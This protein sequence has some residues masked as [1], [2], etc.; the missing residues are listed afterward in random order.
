MRFAI[1]L[2]A[3]AAASP[4]A[5][6][7]PAVE[8]TTVVSLDAVIVSAERT[9]T[10][11][12]SSVSSVS[13]IDA[14]QL[15]QFPQATVADALQQV[16]GFALATFD[17]LGGD[18]Q[19]MVRGFYG[20]GEAEY[21]VVL[22]DGRPFN[23][24]QNGLIAWDAIPLS[25]IE[26]IEVVRGG[27]SA[28]YGDAAIGGV[29]NIITRDVS[30][31]MPAR[32][33]VS[34]G[35]HDTFSGDADVGV[36]LGG[37]GIG[38]SGAIDRTA[39]FRDHAERSSFR[40]GVRA[41]L[42]AG[43]TASL[44]LTAHT[45]ARDFQEA[46]AVLGST[47]DA[48]RA[49]SDPIFRFDETQ[50]R[51]HMLSLLGDAVF[52]ARTRLTGSITGEYR[53]LDAV[54]TLPLAPGYGD[55]KERDT[56]TTRGFATAQLEIDDTFLP[57]ADHL[58]FGADLTAGRF[59]SEYYVI[60]AGTSADYAAASGERG[61]LDASGTGSRAAAGAFAQY[62]VNL[63]RPLRLVL[64]AR[65][66]AVR[67][68]FDASAPSEDDGITASHDEFSPK[69][70]LNFEYARSAARSGNLYI[71]AGR[72][73]KAPTLDQLFDQRSIGVPYP[74]FSVTLSN[75]QLR[76]QYGVNLEA[77]LYHGVA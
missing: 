38:L 55:T 12:G 3:A 28:L 67:D 45:H 14:A 9:S 6:Q 5:A 29:I 21:A 76:P 61:E 68:A 70:G 4:L 75:D 44:D 72:S 74:P 7:R 23:Q 53:D 46:G 56:E 30:G 62:S 2:A 65:F 36:T 11:L 40:L 66:D 1:F 60:M 26:A 64:G 77:G 50:D 49:A 58:L 13:R 52:G 59:D 18:P 27:S 19:L 15:R 32:W 31:D 8:D 63:L 47:L 73:F 35:E 43:P 71:T 16:P 48:S 39:G 33:S 25:A 17:G 37:R 41:P 69:I 20:G 54:R 57:G 51:A 22:L 42:L 24:L 10:L 34:G